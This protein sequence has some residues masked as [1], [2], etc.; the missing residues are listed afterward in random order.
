[1]NHRFVSYSEG[2]DR[3][4]TGNIDGP[5]ISIS[6][7]DGLKNC[8][9]AA[10]IMGEFG[11]TGCF[12]ACPSMVGE[13]DYIKVI[14]F[15]VNQL[16]MPPTELLSWDDVATLLTEGHEVG[17]H[18]M[19]HSDLSQLNIQQVQDEVGESFEMLTRRIGDVKHFAW[20]FGRFFHFSPGAARAVFEAGYTSCASA[21]RGCHGANSK[22]Q[23]RD[24]CIRRDHIVAGWPIS[25]ALYFMARSSRVASIRHETWPA[26]WWAMKGDA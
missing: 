21:E 17:S 5:Y 6:F 11:A 14:E 7:D 15:C 18:T 13:M 20:P 3:V 23:E 4:L 10:R 25:H 2:V 1:M 8:L 26:G 16:G 24:I 9:Q 22:E 19:T 12:F